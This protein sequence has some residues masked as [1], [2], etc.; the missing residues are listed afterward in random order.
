MAQDL[1]SHSS[2]R[3]VA[4]EG[5]AQRRVRALGR[6]SDATI[7]ARD[8]RQTSTDPERL[9]WSHLRN[10]HLDGFRFKR[11]QPVG[12]YFADFACPE[13]LL[14]VEVDGG[15]H[16]DS[17]KDLE[18]DRFLNAA[19]Y[20][21]LRFWNNEVSDELNGVLQIIRLVLQGRPSP[22][23]RF[24]PATLSRDAGEGKTR[25]E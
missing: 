16:S 14:I 12:P 18:R 6:K 21:V 15:Q 24:A 2:A 4:G 8:L 7:K 23:L 1:S 9:L 20:S 5:G 17:Q 13:A 11:Q 3:P 25:K 19:G 10:R 22:G